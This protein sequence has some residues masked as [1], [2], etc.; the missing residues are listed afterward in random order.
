[1]ALY[2]GFLLSPLQCTLTLEIRKRLGD[3]EEI[4]GG[5]VMFEEIEK[6]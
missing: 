2:Q 6:V 5:C 4:F 3:L 1:M